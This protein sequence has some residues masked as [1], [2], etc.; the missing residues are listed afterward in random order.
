VTDETPTPG[1]F[2][3]TV[4]RKALAPGEASGEHAQKTT[5]N[6]TQ[7]TPKR[8]ALGGDHAQR[9]AEAMSQQDAMPETTPVEAASPK[10][11]G[12]RSR[13]RVGLLDR[14]KSAASLTLRAIEFGY[15]HVLSP[16]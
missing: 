11:P 3:A 9:T 12:P 1:L 10:P 14:L 13:P 2:D 6:A 16:P 8:R 4:K 15:Y 7:K 5:Q